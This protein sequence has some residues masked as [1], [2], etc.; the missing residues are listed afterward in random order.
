MSLE[1]ILG[2]VR[3]SL[4]FIGG[5]LIMKGTVDA[6]EWAEMSGLLITLIGGVWS[7][8]DKNKAKKEE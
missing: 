4:T 1:Q 8:V 3:H 5:M 6:T 7:V 2:I